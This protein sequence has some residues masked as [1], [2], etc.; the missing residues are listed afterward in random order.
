MYNTMKEIMFNEAVERMQLL[1]ISEDDIEKFRNGKL[2]KADVDNENMRVCRRDASD[3]DIKLVRE[4]E[5]SK[6]ILV[7]YVI[8]DTGIWPDG[9]KFTRYTLLH[10]DQYESDYEMV[11]DECIGR[12]GTVYAYIV[13]T[14]EPEYSELAEFP[15][16]SVDGILVNLA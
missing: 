12:C 2:T 8:K 9:A 13:N 4:V 16:E 7:Y 11:K 3:E 15:F 6:N 1:N 10:V 14:E 5:E